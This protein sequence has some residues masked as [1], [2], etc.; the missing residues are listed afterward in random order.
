MK[1]HEELINKVRNL[2]SENET[3]K[4]L[5][6]LSKHQLSTLDKELILLSS[7]YS[8]L[9][10]EQRLGIIDESAAQIRTN[11]INLDILNLSELIGKEPP[12]PLVEEPAPV[13]EKKEV[14]KANTKNVSVSK[15]ISK[16]TSKPTAEKKSSNKIALIVGALLLLVG[17]GVGGT[18]FFKQKAEKDAKLEQERIEMEKQK[19]AAAEQA[20]L[21]AEQAKEDSIRMTKIGLGKI[22]EGGIIFY[23]DETKKHGLIM[24]QG[25]VTPNKISWSEK[26][27][28]YYNHV[29]DGRKNT[30]IIV[31]K[32]GDGNYPAKLCYDFEYGVF[33]D[34]YLPS[35]DELDLMW[36]YKIES[37]KNSKMKRPGFSQDYYWSSTEINDKDVYY[38]SF[39]NGKQYYYIKGN[40]A[41]ARPIRQFKF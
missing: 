32:V 31:K 16:T 35:Q 18:L 24:A 26:A 14:E 11:K 2:I 41:K 8:K 27:G 20:K 7:R 33:K 15:T 10:E 19:K 29:L 40:K 17:A 9:A 39:F 38:R 6:L 28:A 30:D 3:E 13:I 36:E 12:P 34:W 23:I 22:F 1:T 37:D 21:A 25:D 4:A 5:E